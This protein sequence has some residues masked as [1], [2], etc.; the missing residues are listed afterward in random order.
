MSPS[1]RTEVLRICYSFGWGIEQVNYLMACMA[2]ESGETFSPSV[3]NAAGSGAV[4]ILQWMPSTAI[5]LGTTTD[6]LASMTAVEQLKYVE[7]YFKPYAK[8]IKSLSDTYAAIIL[9]KYVGKSDS[10][11]LFSGGIAY[12]QNSGLDA[13]KDG[14][15]T[16]GEATAKVQAKLNKGFKPGCVF[17][18]CV[19]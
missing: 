14:K 1:F 3:K 4:G 6:K 10:E 12:R 15:I 5:G 11:V 17:A 7:K 16:K 13:N 19:A 8:K 9:P 2:F 18:E